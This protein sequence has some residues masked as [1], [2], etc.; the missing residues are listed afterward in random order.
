MFDDLVPL[1]LRD[2]LMAGFAACSGLRHVV[3]WTC[4]PALPPE[5]DAYLQAELAR[6]ERV[7]WEIVDRYRRGDLSLDEA[8]ARLEHEFDL[9]RLEPPRLGVV[10]ECPSSAP[11]Q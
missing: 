11:P 2:A 8:V 4:M 10:E 9:D 7:A 6:I 3:A 1:E 5:V